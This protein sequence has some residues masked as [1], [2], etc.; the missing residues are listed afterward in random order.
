MS[1]QINI[2]PYSSQAKQAQIVQ[3]MRCD[4][5]A[6][7]LKTG[8]QLPSINEFSK[9]HQ[10]ARDTIERAYGLLK[11]EGYIIS[12]VGKGYY[13]AN[14]HIE[15]LKVLM[16]LNK[17]S[18]YKMVVYESFISAIGKRAKVDLQIYHYDLNLFRQILTENMGKYHYYVVMPHFFHSVSKEEY[19]QVLND[20]P[21]VAFVVLDRKV[22]LS[23]QIVNV[24]QDFE[25]DILEILE[26]EQ[27]ILKKYN[28]I[29]LVFSDKNH[30]PIEIID[31]VNE[32]CLSQNK[33]FKLVSNVAEIIP[34]KGTAYITLSE[35]ELASLL[36]K[37]RATDLELGKD[38]GILSFN[39]TELKELLGITVV[40]TDFSAMGKIA[41]EM[42]LNKRI[43]SRVRNEFNFIKRSSL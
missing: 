28:A 19:I 16:I 33:Q 2:D 11:R 34:S 14:R 26:K 29:T 21:N 17:V 27:E 38:V 31:G 32:F 8:T 7:R 3:N 23:R 42:I 4:I 13:V 35:N 43:S 39:E 30:H 6:G 22:A 24:F 12:A 15:N 41:A 9:N 36:K 40:S 1:Y 20:F 5:E 18:S 37:I 10:V 25:K